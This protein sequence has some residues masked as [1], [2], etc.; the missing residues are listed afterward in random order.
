MKYLPLLNIVHK[1]SDVETVIDIFENFCRYNGIDEFDNS[2]RIKFVLWSNVLPP[3]NMSIFFAREAK[4]NR[5]D[6]IPNYDVT[7]T[8]SRNAGEKIP[9][10]NQLSGQPRP[11]SPGPT[12]TVSTA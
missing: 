11:A 7:S 1:I 10:E 3:K 12:L 4:R 2:E 6:A 9:D 8:A 5:A